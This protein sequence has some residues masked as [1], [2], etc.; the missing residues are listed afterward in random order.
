MS[1]KDV[2]GTRAGGIGVT[3]LCLATLAAGCGRPLKAG[4]KDAAPPVD[5]GLAAFCTGT[6][7]RMVVNGVGLAPTT[8][9]DY[10]IAMGCCDGGGIVV[11]N[12]ALAFSIDVSWIVEA[13]SSVY[14]LP[15][16]I[17]LASP[18]QGWYVLVNAGCN[19]TAVDCG[20]DADYYQT[21][22]VGWLALARDPSRGIDVSV[23][24]HVEEAQAAPAA[25]LHSLDLYLPHAPTS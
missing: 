14:T 13:S 25:L 16:T 9:S 22:L 4:T 15:A 21:G 24:V 10:P 1:P 6:A 8:V 11:T 20:D 23:C 17:D 12:D 5:G 3:L 7:P 18:P 2:E 19:E